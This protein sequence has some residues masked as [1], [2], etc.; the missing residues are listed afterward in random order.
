MKAKLIFHNKFFRVDGSIVEMKIWHVQKSEKYPYGIKYSLF[1]VDKGYT[2]V[3][4][5]NHAPKGP[6]IHIGTLEKPYIFETVENLIE[7]FFADIER[8]N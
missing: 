7:D 4:Y 3:G 6:H 8:Y 1:W 5:D 2:H